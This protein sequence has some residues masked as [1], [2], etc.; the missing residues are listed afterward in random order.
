MKKEHITLQDVRNKK[1]DNKAIKIEKN[2]FKKS[3]KKIN[4]KKENPFW[5]AKGDIPILISAPHAVRHCR[6]GRVKQSDYLTGSI[7]YLLNEL[8]GCHGISLT[9]NYGGDPNIDSTCIYKRKIKDICSNN[10]IKVF[11]DIHGAAGSKTWDIDFGT[12]SNIN[13]LG[14]I[15]I[16]NI[17]ESSF[18]DFNINKI[19][20]DYFAA[21]L[22]TNV[23]YF[24]ANE[25][26]I[27][28]I[29]VEINRKYRSPK[30]NPENFNFLLSSISKGIIEFIK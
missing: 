28:A 27:P 8:T 14:N 3:D 18:K 21:S 26:G 11:L 16:L 24:V 4:P 23:S 2:L 9:K 10:D 7:V 25:L 22:K 29:Q 6:Y 5:T 30:I 19:S 15:K 12:N 1:L 17:L 20:H 13:L